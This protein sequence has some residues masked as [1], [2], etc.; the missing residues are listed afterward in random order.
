MVTPLTSVM[1]SFAPDNPAAQIAN[2]HTLFNIV[3]TLLLLP[4]GTL[5]AD[6]A[7]RIL[8]EQENESRM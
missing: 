8:P 6:L 4:F 3:T 7:E 1:M 2:M 5:L